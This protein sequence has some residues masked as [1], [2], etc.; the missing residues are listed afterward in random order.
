MGT[1]QMRVTKNGY[2]GRSLDRGGLANDSLLL[3]PNDLSDENGA[4]KDT[5]S[6]IPARR[7]ALVWHGAANPKSNDK[8]FVGKKGRVVH[9]NPISWI[10]PE[11]NSDYDGSDD[12]NDAAI[13]TTPTKRIVSPSTSS[14]RNPRRPFPAE[15][16]DRWEIEERPRTNGIRS[17]KFYHH[18]TD[19][20]TCRSLKDVEKY[21]KDGTMPEPKRKRESKGKDEKEVDGNIAKKK[22]HAEKMRIRAEEFLAESH[23]NL[24]HYFDS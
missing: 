21:E 24:L 17:D 8:I 3:A 23:N 18:K 5:C 15:W 4:G 12:N 6:V 16:K 10:S 14:A 22:K 9:A 13:I 20:F 7:R 2:S 1:T 19:G 11:D